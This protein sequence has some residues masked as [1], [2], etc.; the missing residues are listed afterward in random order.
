[1]VQS[2]LLQGSTLIASLGLI[3]ALIRSP[4]PNKPSFDVNFSDN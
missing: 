3:A 1:L 4:L 2:S